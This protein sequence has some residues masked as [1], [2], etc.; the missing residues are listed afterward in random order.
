MK[1]TSKAQAN[2]GAARAQDGR[3]TLAPYWCAVVIVLAGLAA[4]HN[5]LSAPFVFDDQ[6]S[7][8]ENATI[9]HLQDLRQVLAADT[10]N[11]AG[12]RGRPRI[13]LYQANN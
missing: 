10:G 9:R 5:S 13:N 8:L 11:G 2:A 6:Q 12:A 4:Y 7:I 1:T 3:W